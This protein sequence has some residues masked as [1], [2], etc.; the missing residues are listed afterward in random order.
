M[1]AAM[2]AVAGPAAV[3]HMNKVDGIVRAL[4]AQLKVKPEDIPA[5]V[6]GQPHRCLFHVAG[7]IL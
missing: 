7:L 5:R 3:D 6:A 4:N 1:C 2:Q